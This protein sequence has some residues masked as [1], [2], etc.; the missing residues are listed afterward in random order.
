VWLPF[1]LVEL[2]SVQRE[3]TRAW[4]RAA[5]FQRADDLQEF[6]LESIPG[7]SSFAAMEE[8]HA[9][10]L[11]LVGDGGINVYV[12][13]DLGDHVG[14]AVFVDVAYLTSHVCR[15][16]G[17]NPMTAGLLYLPSA[18]SPAPIEEAAAYAAL[19]ELEYYF[20][21]RTYDGELAPD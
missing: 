19:K 21:S 20:R 12:I 15:Q 16:L 4:M 2:T 13:A 11:S 18:T 10:G 8:M 7:L 14:S 9:M 3:R 17:L 6:L 1:E 5:L